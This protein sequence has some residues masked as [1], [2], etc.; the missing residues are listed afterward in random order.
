[1]RP[2]ARDGLVEQA[3]ERLA[4]AQRNAGELPPVDDHGLGE[5]VSNGVGLLLQGVRREDVAR[6][7][8]VSQPGAMTAHTGFEARVCF[9]RDNRPTHAKF[10]IRTSDVPGSVRYL[11]TG[12]LKDASRVGVRLTQPIAVAVGDRFTIGRERRTLGFGMVTEVIT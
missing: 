3:G 10:Y 1:M 2:G 8:V 9:R 6:G 12:D 5:L 7:Q 11:P 4:L